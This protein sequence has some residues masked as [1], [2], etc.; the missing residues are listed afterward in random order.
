MSVNERQL[1][2]DY[3]KLKSTMYN[4]RAKNYPAVGN[5]A[6]LAETL[7][8]N[9]PLLKRMCSVDGRISYRGKVQVE[10]EFALIFINPEVQSLTAIDASL[11]CDGTFRTRILDSAQVLNLFVEV[12][13]VVS[14]LLSLLLSD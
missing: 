3:D 6:D 1:M 14:L 4:R 7:R 10:N 12:N 8:T 2:K 5:L 11:F 13:G 9:R